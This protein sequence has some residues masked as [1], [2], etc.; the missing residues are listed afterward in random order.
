MEEEGA[1]EKGRD[2]GE[3]GGFGEAMERGSQESGTPEGSTAEGGGPVSKVLLLISDGEDLEGRIDAGL[4]LLEK[5]GA[6]LY[7]F[8]VGTEKGGQIPVRDEDGN[9]RGYKRQGSE[10]VVSRFRPDALRKLATQAKGE[11]FE[12]TDRESDL[13]PLFQDLG[14]MARSE[15]GERKYVIY[16]ER[17]QIP[18]LFAL[19]CLLIELGLSLRARQL[20]SAVLLLMFAPNASAASHPGAYLDNQ[21]GITALKNGRT[22]EALEKELFA[23]D[24]VPD[25]A[26]EFLQKP[27]RFEDLGSLV[28]KLRKL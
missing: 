9:L 22:E 4:K 5:Q 28:E 18:V 2:R 25:K 20:A 12:L 21:E 8:G 14:K 23:Q 24:F 7:V 16:N 11:Y 6:R 27:F 1:P 13:E 17:F 26:I 10:F 3:F 19:L 15:V